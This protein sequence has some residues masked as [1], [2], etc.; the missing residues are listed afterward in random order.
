MV[1]R[2]SISPSWE[3][4]PNYRCVHSKPGS[5]LSEGGQETLWA[6]RKLDTGSS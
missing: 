4:G 5:L 3:W 1:R 2:G 6:S